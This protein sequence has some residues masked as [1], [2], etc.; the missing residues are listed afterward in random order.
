MTFLILT[1]VAKLHVCRKFYS[2]SVSDKTTGMDPAKNFWGYAVP[3]D[4]I[5]VPR[6]A[7]TTFR[8]EFCG[9]TGLKLLKRPAADDFFENNLF[10]SNFQAF[11]V[12]PGGGYNP[13]G[14]A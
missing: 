13:L 4:N 5:L 7:I 10:L 9:K 11:L 14:R 3:R 12:F 1:P 6:P 2:L 8:S